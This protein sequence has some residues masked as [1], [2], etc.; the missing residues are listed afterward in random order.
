VH[1]GGVV[2]TDVPE[3]VAWATSDLAAGD[4]VLFSALTVH[5]AL[6][7]VTSDRLRV[8]VDFRYRP[9]SGE[10]CADRLSRRLRPA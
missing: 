7:N 10:T 8:S 9:A 5:R 1:G 6:D 3:N 2:G 4:V